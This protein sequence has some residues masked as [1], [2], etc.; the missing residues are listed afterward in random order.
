MAIPGREHYSGDYLGPQA[1]RILSYRE[2]CLYTLQTKPRMVLLVGKGDGLAGRMLQQ[3]GVNVVT[4]DIEPGLS[5][6]IAASVEA[7]PLAGKSVDVSV[8]CQVLEHLPFDRFSGTLREL[9]RVT[10]DR[11]VLSLP[12][13]RRSVSFQM[14]VS[15][16]KVAWSASLPS[17]WPALIPEWRKR[18][19]GHYW[20]IGYAGTTFRQ[21]CARV[22]DAGWRVLEVRRVDGFVWHTFFY[23]APNAAEH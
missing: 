6:D 8:C 15:R 7:I 2:Q 14:S 3:A 5:P 22:R 23:C 18:D 1:R 20:E 9:R 21:V 16:L 11:L 12:D 10:R 17:L 4:L 13:I 19:F